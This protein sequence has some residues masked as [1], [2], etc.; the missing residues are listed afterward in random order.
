[1]P[2]LVRTVESSQSGMAS[3]C[4]PATCQGKNAFISAEMFQQSKTISVAALFDSDWDSE[5]I[6]QT[7]KV[8]V[9]KNHSVGRK[10]VLLLLPIWTL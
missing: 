6:K 5:Y 9:Q 2:Y 1:M 4:K 8:V 10:N 3:Y 7:S